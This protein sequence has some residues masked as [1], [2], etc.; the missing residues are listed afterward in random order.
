M[1]SQ[2]FIRNSL[3]LISIEIMAK[4]LGVVFF[5]VVARFLGAR[6][7]G[8]FAFA[9]AVANFV[10][11]PAKFGFEDL[12]Q[13]EVSRH[14]GGTYSYFLSLGSIK[15]LI[16]VTSLGIFAL[17]ALLW[18]RTDPAVLTLAVAF[19]LVYSFM[20]FT[21]SFFRANQRAELEMAVRLFFSVGNILLGIT[22]L[23][24]GYR[25]KGV[26]SMQLLSVGA[27]VVL[28]FFILKRLAGWPEQPEWQWRA[29]WRKVAAA[30]PFAGILVALYLSNQIGVVF[31]NFLADKTAVGYFAS[32]TRI[33]DAMTLIPAAITGAFLPVMSLYFVRCTSAFVRTLRFTLKYMFIF[34]VPLLVITS[35]LAD[36]II[37]FLYKQ[38]FAASIPALRILGLALVFSFW[39]FVGQ[40]VLVARNRERLLLGSIWVVAGVH[41]LGNLLFIMGYSYL[42][43]CWAI[44]TTQAI[45]C[46]ILYAI[47]LRRYVGLGQLLR[48]IAAPALA[49]AV[50][51]LA[52]YLLRPAHLFLAVL[53]G[54]GVYVG[55]LFALGAV[56]PADQSFFRRLVATKTQDAAVGL[57]ED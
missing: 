37:I 21:N 19:T 47:S 31:L 49:G 39:S 5:I 16:S 48:L 22:I 18:S 52:V 57:G 10:V 34:A 9:I 50:M 33:F 14:P 25:L 40:S 41:V 46:V 20:E 6:D 44:C 4:G 15:G 2:K 54:L 30:L 7:L 42:G 45:Y 8:T 26:L 29:S 3:L 13:R 11:I 24:A 38:A 56:T 23:Y 17:G 12:V 55:A 43:A 32:A 28:A 51:G 27:S 36:R 53:G 1:S 35:L